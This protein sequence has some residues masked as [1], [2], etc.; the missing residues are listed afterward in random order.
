MI[1]RIITN[2]KKMMK[3]RG[4]KIKEEYQENKMIFENN[5]IVLFYLDEKIKIDTIKE[6]KENYHDYSHYILI[7]NDKITSKAFKELEALE[8]EFE[9]FYKIELLINILEHESQPEIRILNKKEEEIIKKLYG[10]KIMRYTLED[11]VVK[12]FNAKVGNI[13]EI[14]DKDQ[15]IRYRIVTKIE[16]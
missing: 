3:V 16:K 2:I 4:I 9:I 10:N 6:L 13:F 8:Q 11:K 1:N 7:T 12:Y 14:K 15:N 5:I